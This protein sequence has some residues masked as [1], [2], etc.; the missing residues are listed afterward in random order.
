MHRYC[1]PNVVARH[2]NGIALQSVKK[3]K[4]GQYTSKTS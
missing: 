2:I 1:Q 4:T 3:H